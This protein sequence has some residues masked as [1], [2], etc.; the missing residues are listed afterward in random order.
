MSKKK[1]EKHSNSTEKRKKNTKIH[2][3]S[4]KRAYNIGQDFD[5]ISPQMKTLNKKDEYMTMTTYL[6]RS[7]IDDYDFFELE[8][9]NFKFYYKSL[10]KNENLIKRALQQVL[11]RNYIFLIVS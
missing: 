1:H 10:I 6:D 8:N 5:S 4:P 11:I 9:L 7:K 3:W 2:V